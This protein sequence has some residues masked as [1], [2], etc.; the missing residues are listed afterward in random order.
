MRNIWLLAF[1]LVSTVNLAAVALEH[2]PFIFITKPLLMPLLAIWLGAE[3]RDLPP[4]FLKKMM[5]AGLAFS[6]LGD[7]LLLWGEQPFFFM[8]GLAAF[9]FTHFSYIGGFSSICGLDKGLLNRQSWR[10][11]PF[12]AY[13]LGL[14]WLLWPGIPFGMKLPV[15]IYAAVIT[16]MMLS[17]INLQGSVSAKIYWTLFAGAALFLLSDSLIAAGKFGGNPAFR[18]GLAVMATYLSGQFLIV[19]GVRDVLKQ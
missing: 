1:A 2:K 4:R 7:V 16:A 11:L 5:F 3:T 12:V 13:A 14:L 9:L 10:A 15:S 18:S 17:V 6:T 8:L 19:K